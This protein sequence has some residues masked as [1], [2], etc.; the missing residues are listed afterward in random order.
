MGT[1]IA[2]PSAEGVIE[3]IEKI[4]SF[5]LYIYLIPSLSKFWFQEPCLRKKH[6]PGDSFDSIIDSLKSPSKET[7]E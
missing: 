7:V 2:L 3:Q 1:G 6:K 5:D 4:K